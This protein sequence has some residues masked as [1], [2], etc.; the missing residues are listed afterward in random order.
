MR[1]T[2]AA[3]ALTLLIAAPSLV[4]ASPAPQFGSPTESMGRL[5]TP[6]QKSIAACSRGLREKKKADEE[7]DPQKKIKL[8]EKAKEDLL[9]AAG[10]QPNFDAYLALGQ[11][12][13]ALGKLPSA[14]SACSQAQGMKPTNEA[15]KSCLEEARKPQ[16]KVE[17]TAA[18]GGGGR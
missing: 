17:E 18:G 9:K 2:F 10:Y 7:K 3:T 13:L 15:A 6:E 8:Y 5:D 16:V 4:G 11:I 14:E 12:Y 1:R